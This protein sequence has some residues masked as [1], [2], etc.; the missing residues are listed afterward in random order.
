MNKIYFLLLLG[1]A[2]LGTAPSIA[3]SGY[4][5]FTPEE[6][7][8]ERKAAKQGNRDAQ[9]NLGYVYYYGEG[10]AQDYQKA[11]HWYRRCSKLPRCDV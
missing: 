8:I 5:P 2:V 1:F 9:Y 3:D 10:V 6:V 11:M 7:E 4:E